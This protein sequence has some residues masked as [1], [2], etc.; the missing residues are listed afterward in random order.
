MV[1]EAE[2]GH[3]IGERQQKVVARVVARAEERARLDDQP[4]DR[5]EVRRLDLQ[6]R[7]GLGDHV[8]EVLRL[9]AAAG[10]ERVRLEERA[11]DDRRIDQRLQR[12]RLELD[13]VAGDAR[14]L[15]R[16]A[17]LPAARQQQLRRDDELALADALGIEH[18]QVPLDVDELRARRS[19]ARVELAFD[20]RQVVEADV[21][22]GDAR[23]HGR[24]D[25]V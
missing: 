17:V 6:R 15:E 24:V 16:A 22:R 18:D 1:L 11:G 4:L 3:A 10:A 21:D 12:H 9:A 14:G 7:L 8:E 2:V 20:R 19:A 13:G 5:V 25:R 23:R